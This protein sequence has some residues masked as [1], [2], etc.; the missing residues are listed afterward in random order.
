MENP[1]SLLEGNYPKKLNRI[2]RITRFFVEKGIDTE[3]DLEIWLENKINITRLKNVGYRKQN[4][5]RNG[6]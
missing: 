5:R 4:C 3:N 1:S 6:N 2:L